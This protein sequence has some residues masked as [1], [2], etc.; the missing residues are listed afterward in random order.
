M[1]QGSKGS[2]WTE[3]SL[4]SRWGLS[5]M[6]KCGGNTVGLSPRSGFGRSG[7]GQDDW[8]EQ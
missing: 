3:R 5:D 8:T 7:W 6:E 1:G 2:W 4:E